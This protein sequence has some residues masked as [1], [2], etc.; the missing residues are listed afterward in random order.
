MVFGAY[1][2]YRI[3][4]NSLAA[5]RNICNCR[6]MHESSAV[7]ERYVTIVKRILPCI[8]WSSRYTFELKIKLL[9]V[10][11]VYMAIRIAA[12]MITHPWKISSLFLRLLSWWSLSIIFPL[13][14]YVHMHR[15]DMY[16]LI[17]NSE[18]SDVKIVPSA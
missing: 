2:L 4:N 12:V 1:R 11:W 10:M 17:I 3:P 8:L 18:P 6:R 7:K 13:I 15:M 16:A 9:R 5:G 14:I